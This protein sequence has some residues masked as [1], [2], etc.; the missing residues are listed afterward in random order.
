MAAVKVVSGRTIANVLPLNTMVPTD[1][2]TAA[3]PAAWKA[4]AE[5]SSNSLDSALTVIAFAVKFPPTL[6]VVV[7]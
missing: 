1:A 2:P 3:V 5:S 7:S 6:A 4:V